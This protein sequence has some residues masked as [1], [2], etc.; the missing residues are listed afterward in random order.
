MMKRLPL[1]LTTVS[2]LLASVSI[3]CIAQD[4]KPY[5]SSKLDEKASHDASGAAPGKESVVYTTGDSFEQVYAFY[6]GQY[7]E[8]TMRHGPMPLPTGQQI[9]WAFF[10]LDGGKDL[11]TSKYWMKIQRPYVG[12]TDGKDI[13]DVTVIQTVRSK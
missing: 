7:K 11:L 10:I 4:F 3:Q 8:F 2:L 9:K 1:L 5:A 13:R 6:K 12:G